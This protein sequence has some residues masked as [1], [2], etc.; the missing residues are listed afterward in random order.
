MNQVSMP[1]RQVDTNARALEREIAWLS[2]LLEARFHHYFAQSPEPFTPVAPP[3][4]DG[5][6]SV[7]ALVREFAMGDDERVVLALAL[8]PHLRPQALDLLF[9]QNQVQSKRFT[10]FGGWKG[11]THEGFLPT[12]ETAAFILAGDDLARRIDVAALFD[13]SHFFARA[14]LLRIELGA[15][16]GGSL[17]PAFS[18]R[19]SVTPDC[20]RRL[21]TGAR[22]KPD[23]SANFPAKLITTTLGWADLVLAHEV[24]TEID[25]IG[26]WLAASG[27]LLAQWGLER[28][29]KPG[30]RCLFYGPP[31]TGKTLTATL[32][33]VVGNAD[34][35]RVDLSMV[36]SKYIGET[37]KNL[38]NVFDQAQDKRWILFFDEADALFGKRTQGSG[39]NDRHANQEISYLLQ[40]IEDFPGMVILASNL[41]GNIDEAFAR[42]FQ[43]AIYF[44]MPDAEHRLI[45]WRRVFQDPARIGPDV[46]FTALADSYEL[47]GGAITNVAR[48]AAIQASR[49]RR[50]VVSQHDLLTGITKELIKEGRTH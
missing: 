6:S 9:T 43:S 47:A 29:V 25:N 23:Y 49:L 44:P 7:A 19:L 21:T 14:R 36:V 45:L 39:A 42:R 2:G 34:V 16:Q 50:S 22:H 5:D 46:D 38:A 41:R 13:D 37:E 31:G 35:Y 10:E 4:L 32:M 1:M 26:L 12:C 28:T 40:R 48:Y 20:L 24:R 15:E 8:A 27:T 30:Y 33:G 3:G 17:E 11:R 18:A